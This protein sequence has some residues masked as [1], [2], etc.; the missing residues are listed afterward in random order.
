[1]GLQPLCEILGISPKAA[2]ML[3]YG[4]TM[5]GAYLLKRGLF[6]PWELAPLM[7]KH[8]AKQGL[9]RL[10][11]LKMLN[12][13]VAGAHSDVEKV[14][15]LEQTFYMKNQL[16]RDADWAGMS[17]SLEIRVPFVDVQLQAAIG[18]AQFCKTD[19][20][21]T[22]AEL[23]PEELAGRPK[24]GFSTPLDHWR[25]YPGAGWARHWAKELACE[26]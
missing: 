20:L 19:L 5:G 11:L 7:G 17:H 4:S 16:L 14:S 10:G 12:G 9:Q 8:A 23:L 22:A 15:R 2:G 13:T 25:G 26:F 6:M 18:G 3:E 24:T 1:M 21:A